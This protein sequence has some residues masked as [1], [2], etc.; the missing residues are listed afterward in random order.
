MNH[1]P[2]SSPAAPL[3]GDALHALIDQ[4]QELLDEYSETGASIEYGDRLAAVQELMQQQQFA[5]TSIMELERVH[6]FW[7][8]LQRPQAANALLQA[9]GDQL[10]QDVTDPVQRTEAALRLALSDIQSRRLF[11]RE[12]ASALLQP[13]LRL[14]EQL[15][16]GTPA[17]NYWDGWLYLARECQAYALAEQGLDLRLAQDSENLQIAEEDQAWFL[18]ANSLDKAELAQL[19]NDQ[20]LLQRHVQQALATLRDAGDDQNLD[21]SQWMELARRLLPVAPNSL[22]S[23]LISCEQWLARNEEPAPSLAVKTHRKTRM[24]RLQA[25]ACHLAGQLDAAIQLGLQS[26][27]SLTDDHGDPFSGL[28]LQWLEQAG[29]LDQAAELALECV[30]HARPGSAEAAYQLALAQFDKDTPQTCTWALV[31]AWSQIDEDMRQLLAD[32][33]AAPHPATHYLDLVRARAPGHHLLALIEGLELA[34]KHQMDQALPLLEQAVT[35]HPELADG[36]KLTALWAARFCALAP[37]DAV[38][39]PFPEAHGGHWCYAAGV[40]LDDEDDLASSMGGHTKV[41]SEEVR[42]PLVVRYYEEG[43]ARFEQF[44]STGQGSFKDGDLHVY[45]M[46]CNNLAIK[47]RDQDRYDEAEDLHQRGLASSPF[48]EHLDGLWWCANGRDDDVAIIGAAERLWHFARE[49]GFSRHEPQRYF[50]TVAL[51]LYKLDRGD[52]ISIWLERLDDWYA[53]LDAEEKQQE[54]RDYLAAQMSLL[55]FLSAFRPEP[56]LPRLRAHLEEIRALQDCYVLR[57]LA[58]A[59]EAYPELL[60]ECLA[61]HREAATHLGK[62]VDKDFALGDDNDFEARASQQ[63]IERTEQKLAEYKQRGA[64]ARPWWKFW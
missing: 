26:R 64:T 33:D 38:T 30:L 35:S 12:T 8:F 48:A 18:A 1:A 45:S 55:D 28:V 32:Q 52:E 13:A 2:T 6:D 37:Q 41:P 21:F 51:S 61:L 10:L 42:V 20:G 50:P 14:L 53:D 23:L 62:N 63:G 58:C 39:R 44:W 27:T 5:P 40:T 15:P 36:D 49:H 11:D 7:L 4:A 31:L 43:L 46:L 54:R 17:G 25:Q 29:R 59:M 34:R 9:H 16:I 22:P 47:Y 19:R 3:H 57:R 60:E 24:A 56:V